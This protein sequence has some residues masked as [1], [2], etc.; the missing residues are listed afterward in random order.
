MR[1]P[2]TVV[3]KQHSYGVYGGTTQQNGL[4]DDIICQLSASILLQA[5]E[6]WVHCMRLDQYQRGDVT[7][8][9]VN[10]F[11]TTHGGASNYAEI[12]SF[13]RGGFGSAICELMGLD[14]EVVLERLE[15]W[16]ANYEKTGEIPK[17]LLPG[18]YLSGR[19]P[20]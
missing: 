1:K 5:I 10:S 13:L 20:T 12:R 19:R 14:S 4:N 15:K 7:S 17:N 9:Q 11:R 18:K 3:H 16:L 2:R 6:D 8:N